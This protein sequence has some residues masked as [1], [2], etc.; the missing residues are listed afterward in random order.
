LPWRPANQSNQPRKIA[1][2]PTATPA[3]FT[4]SERLPTAA[5]FVEP[6]LVAE[7]VDVLVDP[8][9]TWLTT[10]TATLEEL[11]QVS[12]ERVVALL[13]KVISAQLYKA[14]PVWPNV[15]TW[16]LAFWPSAGLMPAGRSRCDKQRVPFPVS[17]SGCCVKE[18]LKT[19]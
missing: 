15:T 19:G 13:L 3:A 7:E 17:L 6:E 9:T 8:L 2:N 18:M 11:V 12:P 10:E 16:I 1:P 4:S 14:L 5:L